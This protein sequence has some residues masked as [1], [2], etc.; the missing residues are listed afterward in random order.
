MEKSLYGGKKKQDLKENVN[1][2][3]WIT[4]NFFE[5]RHNGDPAGSTSFL[6]LETISTV[7]TLSAACLAKRPPRQ[8]FKLIFYLIKRNLKCLINAEIKS[9]Y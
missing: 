9:G 3:C 1:M 4:E 6:L 5:C 8:M 2:S 7:P